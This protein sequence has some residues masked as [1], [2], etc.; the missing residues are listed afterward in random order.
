MG[1]DSNNVLATAIQAYRLEL[2]GASLNQE[3]DFGRVIVTFLQHP[4]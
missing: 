3:E 1:E 2:P 4:P